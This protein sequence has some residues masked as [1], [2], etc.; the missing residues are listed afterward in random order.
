MNPTPQAARGQR[1]A[2]ESP[3]PSEAPPSTPPPTVPPAED[4]RGAEPPIKL[5]GQPGP[6]ERVRP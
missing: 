3:E 5:P 1:L 4:E 6:P 2:P